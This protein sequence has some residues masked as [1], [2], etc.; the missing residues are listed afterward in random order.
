[1]TVTTEH[2]RTILERLTQAGIS[3]DRAR[4]YLAVGR[5][6]VD[7]VVVTDP[8]FPA[9]RRAHVDLRYPRYGER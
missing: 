3:E 7:D 5:V 2:V 8:A 6:L 4:S 9:A 1:M